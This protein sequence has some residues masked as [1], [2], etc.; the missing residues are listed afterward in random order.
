MAKEATATDIIHTHTD[1]HTQKRRARILFPGEG[2]GGE[3][4]CCCDGVAAVAMADGLKE[5]AST[6]T[7]E[8]KPLCVYLTTTS[9]AALRRCVELRAA[10][11]D[12]EG[13]GSIPLLLVPFTSTSSSSSS[14]SS[15]VVEGTSFQIRSFNAHSTLHHAQ[16]GRGPWLL[17]ISSDSSKHPRSPCCCF[18]FFFFFFFPVP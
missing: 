8:K 6:H 13:S 17:G 15:V 5:K 12:S 16:R 18:F 7:H 11:L 14:S 3:R 4:M 2:G 9:A 1:R 10:H